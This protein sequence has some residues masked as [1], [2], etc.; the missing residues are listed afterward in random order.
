MTEKTPMMNQAFSTLDKPR[1][2]IVEDNEDTQQ[3]Y[4][5][6]FERDN[7]SVM[8]ADDGQKGLAYAQSTLP[9]VILL[10]L[11]L[12]KIGGMEILKRLRAAEDT[13]DIPVMVFSARSD[14]R[15]MEQALELGVTEYSVKA[16]NTPKQMLARVRAML[17]KSKRPV[18]TSGSFRI[19]LKDAS[20]EIQR[21]QADLGFPKGFHCPTC[22]ADIVLDMIRDNTRAEGH[23][24]ATHFVCS[25]CRAS[26]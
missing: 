9:D 14:S 23:W 21:L 1:L 2:L 15:D 10:D 20:P 7:F 22:Q 19:A 13:R 5:E 3:I 6:I 25:A 17:S 26:F 16:L 12:P 4:K 18:A 24:Y 8:I 11:M